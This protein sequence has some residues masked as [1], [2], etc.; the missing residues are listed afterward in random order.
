MQNHPVIEFYAKTQTEVDSGVLW[1]LHLIASVEELVRQ[2]DDLHPEVCY[3]PG[4][5]EKLTYKDDVLTVEWR[6]VL[7]KGCFSNLFRAALKVDGTPC[8]VV[9]L[10]PEDPDE[11]DAPDNEK[12]D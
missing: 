10:A 3:W 8:E 12:G 6:D 1:L 7:D 2:D 4:A 9:Y 5:L 11:M